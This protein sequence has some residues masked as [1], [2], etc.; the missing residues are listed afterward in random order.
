MI[1]YKNCLRVSFT[2]L[3]TGFFLLI[4]SS[5]VKIM[6]RR[7]CYNI[8]QRC[9]VNDFKQKMD[10]AENHLLNCDNYSEEDKKKL[11]A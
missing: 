8:M 6:T 1:F 5:E 10:Y 3:V 2:I 7:Q 4:G 9:D 11:K